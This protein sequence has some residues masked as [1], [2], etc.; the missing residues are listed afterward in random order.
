[1]DE[2]WICLAMLTYP[3]PGDVR[4]WEAAAAIKGEFDRLPTGYVA[5]LKSDPRVTRTGETIKIASM[6]ALELARDA[7]ILGEH[8]R[9]EFDVRPATYLDM[10]IDAVQTVVETLCETED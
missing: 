10:A 1:M 3:G 7:G 5:I 2:L 9:G 4:R 6:R 8:E